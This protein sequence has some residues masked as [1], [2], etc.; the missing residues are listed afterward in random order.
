MPLNL[1][2]FAAITVPL[3]AT[4]GAS[5]AVVLRN[6]VAGGTRSGVATAV[7]ANTGSLCY[8]LLTAFGVSVVLQRWPLLW[9][10][11][12]VG[13][14]LYLGWLGVRSLRRARSYVQPEPGADAFAA[15]PPLARS[16][17]EGFVTNV[18]N[19]SLATFYLLVLPEFI[20]RGAPFAASAMTLTAIHVSLAA[21]W[22]VTWAAAGG[23]LA[24][25]LSRTGPRRALEAISGIALVALAVTLA[26]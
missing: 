22:H 12:R 2:A 1:W 14:A 7:G 8:G 5:T 9:M 3:V 15:R 11:L 18:L 4:P 25:T 23:T 6:A 16:V 10:G 17:R 24:A 21:A 26:I 13:G 20:P 19:P